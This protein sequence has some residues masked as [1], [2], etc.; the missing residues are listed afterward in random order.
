M[1]QTQQVVLHFLRRIFDVIDNWVLYVLED[2]LPGLH[3]DSGNEDLPM[4][5]TTTR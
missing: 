2:A 1:D 4:Y 3:R 5:H